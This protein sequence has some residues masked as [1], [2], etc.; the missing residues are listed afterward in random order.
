[1]RLM[2]TLAL[3]LALALLL[4]S[5][6]AAATLRYDDLTY[7]VTI[8]PDTGS[9]V[10]DIVVEVHGVDQP[11]SDL[12]LV[13]DA[14]LAPSSASIDGMGSSYVETMAPPFRAV[15]VVPDTPVP[16]GQAVTVRVAYSGVLLCGDYEPGSSLCDYGPGAMGRFQRGSVFPTFFDSTNAPGNYFDHRT[17]TLRVPT[18]VPAWYNGTPL[19]DQD[20]GVVRTLTFEENGPSPN[21]PSAYA[22]ALELEVLDEGPPAIY[23]AHATGDK[24]W[25]RIA[26]WIPRAYAFVE[27]KVGLSL[28]CTTVFIVKLEDYHRDIGHAGTCFAQL[29]PHHASLGEE[30]FEESWSHEIA[31]F[32]WGMTVLPGDGDQTQMTTEGLSTNLQID[33]THDTHHADEDR[34]WYRAR[35]FREAR[36]MLEYAAPVAAATPVLT[37]PEGYNA[38]A[39]NPDTD[40]RFAWSYLKSS[41]TLDYLKLHI[42]EEAYDA[43]VRDFTAACIG[44]ACTVDDLRGHAESASGKDLAPFFDAW[45]RTTR[46]PELAVG[47]SPSGT[48]VKLAVPES[49]ATYMPLEIWLEHEDG[50]RTKERV[51]L[52]AGKREVA[53]TVATPVRAARPNPRHEA[54]IRVRSARGS[55]M[56][57]DQQVDGFDLLDCAWRHGIALPMPRFSTENPNDGQRDGFIGVVDLDFDPRCDT[58]HD[59]DIDDDDLEAMSADFGAGAV[60]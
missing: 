37:T 23:F 58:D 32:W 60:R 54:L 15:T 1:M 59:G 51:L 29:H 18:G 40:D 41:A 36:L 8:D 57:F 48:E 28:P 26:E 4:G 39:K 30:Q 45:V 2:T 10:A 34:D 31:H 46:M 20:D 19:D 27:D 9:V 53:V 35:R 14:G 12:T 50:S 43:A 5:S 25:A 56:D 17:V 55:D 33:Y 13:V 16:A 52:E 49:D 11:L 3:A 38:A 21:Y 42:G 47:L 22:G 44:A 24:S 6:T 7:D